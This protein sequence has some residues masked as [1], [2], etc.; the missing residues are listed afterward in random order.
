MNDW[1][2]KQIETGWADLKGL[3]IKATVPLRDSVIN[4]AIAE[5]LGASAAPRSAGPDLRGLLPLVKHA[6]VHTTEG[7]VVIDVEISV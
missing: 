4:D 6:Q 7:T 2:R 5:L 1:F 3:N